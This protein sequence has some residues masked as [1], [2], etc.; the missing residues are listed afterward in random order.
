MSSTPIAGNSPWVLVSTTSCDFQNNGGMPLR[1]TFSTGVPAPSIN[2]FVLL[3]GDLRSADLVGGVQ[4]WV[5]NPNDVDV[6]LPE[7]VSW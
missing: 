5:K 6:S 2:G 4:F 3:P 1:Y 7:V